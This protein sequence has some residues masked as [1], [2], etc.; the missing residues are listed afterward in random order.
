MSERFER[1]Q[2]DDE[3]LS[4]IAGGITCRST[5]KGVK[6]CWADDDPSTIYTFND[7]QAIYDFQMYHPEYNTDATLIP[8]LCEAGIIWPE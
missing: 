8:A 3:Q 1:V 6:Q 5:R 2:L 7:V 4:K